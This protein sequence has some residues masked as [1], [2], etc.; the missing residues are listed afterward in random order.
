MVI[1]PTAPAK[2]HFFSY[3][4]AFLFFS[5]VLVSNLILTP[6]LRITGMDIQLILYLIN[7]IAISSGMTAVIVF[8]EKKFRGKKQTTA[9]FMTLLLTCLI[10]CY[11]IVYR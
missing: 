4:S 7:T 11:F 2:L 9:L 3:K 1:P 10:V 8:V 5:F 6:L